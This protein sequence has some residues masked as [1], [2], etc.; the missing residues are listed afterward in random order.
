MSERKLATIQEI[1]IINPIVGKDR[2]GLATMKGLGWHVIVNKEDIHVGDKVV[3]FEIDSILDSS[4]PKF[5]FMAKRR[6]RVKT[7]KMAGVFSQ[8]LCVPVKELDMQNKKVGDDVTELL[9]ITKY[10][11]EAQQERQFARVEKHNKFVKFMLRF[12]LFRFIYYWD[13]PGVRTF[14]TSW[15]SKTDEE[16]IQVKPYVT[17]MYENEY[18]D[19]SE[20][21][22]GQS[23]TYLLKPC[24]SPWQKWDF[25]VCSRNLQVDETGSSTYAFINK[26]YNMKEKCIELLK[27]VK[28]RLPK[29]SIC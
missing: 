23:A 29:S 25:Q 1:E 19:C 16:R 2:I 22:D 14:P 17:S 21:I 6:F 28:K 26:K 15:V 7:M 18:I 13:R 11:P 10:D 24:K 3:Y 27:R 5:E 4:N 8:G 9:K 20:K 12:K